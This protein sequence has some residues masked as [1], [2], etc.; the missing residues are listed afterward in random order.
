MLQRCDDAKCKSYPYYGGRGITV[1]DRWRQFENFLA[2]MG[3]RPRGM[4]IERKDNDGN[5]EPGNCKWATRSEQ[6][7]NTR[8]TVHV[9]VAGRTMRLRTACEERGLSYNMVRQRLQTYGWS[10]ERALGSSP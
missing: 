10:V 7:R 6:A 8:R 2:D 9:T 5:Y 1:C 4:S 3:K